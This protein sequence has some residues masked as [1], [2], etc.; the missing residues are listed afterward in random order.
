[1]AGL[2]LSPGTV[3]AAGTDYALVAGLPGA[4]TEPDG[5]QM[6]PERLNERRIRKARDWTDEQLTEAAEAVG[7]EPIDPFRML[8]GIPRDSLRI[9]MLDEIFPDAR[10][11]YVNRDPAQAMSRMAAIWQAGTMVTREELPG[12]DGPPW[13][14]P[15]IPGWREL[16]GS[17]LEE[18]VTAQWIALSRGALDE[19]EQL[20]PERWCVSDFDQLTGNRDNETQ[21]ICRFLDLGW[22]AGISNAVATSLATSER[23][24]A[25]IESKPEVEPDEAAIE[26]SNRARE[27]I[28]DNTPKRNPG[29]PE[30]G[31][32]PLRSVYTQGVPEIFNRIKSSLLISTYQSGRLI[33]ARYEDGRLNT[34]FRSF[35]RPMGIAVRD[36][37]LRRRLRQ[38]QQRLPTGPRR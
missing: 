32:E 14:M 10:F 15:L 4:S 23:E 6:G 2:S 20:V 16:S 1:M 30:A 27:L 38:R 36:D 22:H 7:G 29:A 17:P 26:I 19:L 11:V 21:R 25:A 8:G 5:D 35:D 9:G 12:W 18:L 13:S 3:G 37:W 33:C 28:A 31:L 34:H 24:F